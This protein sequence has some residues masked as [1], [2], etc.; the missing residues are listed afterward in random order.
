MPPL[1]PAFAPYQDVLARALSPA[2]HHCP[3]YRE[4]DRE[5]RREGARE[6]GGGRG[7]EKREI[8]DLVC[9]CSFTAGLRFESIYTRTQSHACT[10]EYLNIYIPANN[11]RTY[12]QV[13]H[14]C[15][16]TYTCHTYINTSVH[17]YMHT[18]ADRNIPAPTRHPAPKVTDSQVERICKLFHARSCVSSCAQLLA[19]NNMYVH[20][21]YICIYIYI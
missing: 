1:I 19:V 10:H 18:H 16:H 4:G 7:L 20:I 3:T 17:T 9:Y 8:R 14:P 21:I 5:G 13:V 11:I 12:T 6:R 2:A 15:I